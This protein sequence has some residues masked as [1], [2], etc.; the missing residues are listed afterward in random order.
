MLLTAAP[1]VLLLTGLWLPVLLALGAAYTALA[2]RVGRR[3]G[4]R[5]LVAVWGASTG[6]AA[7]AVAALTAA[8]A[9]TWGGRQ[10]LRAGL[11]TFGLAALPLALCLGAVTAVV[12][13]RLAAGL[14]LG[15]GG[16]AA[17]AGAAAAA[18]VAC[19]ALAVFV[20]RVV[21]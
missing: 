2:W 12:R 16:I 5:G 13:G 17:G 6:M 10:G 9:T 19:A 20:L 1:T 14:R 21:R 3:G 11:A 18:W 4:D 7:A 15:V 8:Q